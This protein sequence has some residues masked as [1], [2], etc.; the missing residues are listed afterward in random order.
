MH[1]TTQINNQPLNQ[2]FNNQQSNTSTDTQ[3]TTLPNQHKTNYG[4]KQSPQTPKQSN[5]NNLFKQP[6][7]HHATD[8]SNNNQ[9]PLNTP[10]YKTPVKQTFNHE[11]TRQHTQQ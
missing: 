7:K 1:P 9:Q 11:H 4:S 5:N 10:S 6:I 2:P 3:N 8:Y